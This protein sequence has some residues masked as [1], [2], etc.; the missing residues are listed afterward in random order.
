MSYA[1][2]N[3][4]IDELKQATLSCEAIISFTRS[5]ILTN[6]IDDDALRGLTLE[7]ISGNV[8]S[9]ESRFEAI[10][11][12][13]LKAIKDALKNL[14]DLFKRLVRFIM[15]TKRKAQKANSDIKRAK[16]LP[17]NKLQEKLD[18]LKELNSFNPRS[19]E[20]I[21]VHGSLDPDT[22]HKGLVRY[23]DHLSNLD[24]AFQIAH[25]TDM[26][27][28]DELIKDIM[29]LCRSVAENKY[30]DTLAMSES[31]RILNDYTRDF[32]EAP[33]RQQ[34]YDLMA[35][36]VPNPLCG[37][38]RLRFNEPNDINSYEF[39]RS[40][41]H[42]DPVVLPNIDQVITL[43]DAFLDLSSAYISIVDSPTGRFDGEIASE[44]D[45]DEFGRYIEVMQDSTAYPKIRNNIMSA[46]NL[47]SK[48]AALRYLQYPSTLLGKVLQTMLA[49]ERYLMAIYS[50]K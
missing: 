43:S 50:T 28:A 12:S 9:V 8:F 29:T 21:R 1:E 25:N 46:I 10:V 13:I 14:R 35:A 36:L 42:S 30:S 45:G 16:N 48:F 11:K 33:H 38:I 4:G 47:I 39:I 17:I 3:E 18:T 49:L 20:Y 5:A 7:S 41:A 27:M 6:Q 40:K 23:I 15:G 24:K 19:V 32:N 37:N 26:K 2:I 22:I 31:E 44:F 34:L